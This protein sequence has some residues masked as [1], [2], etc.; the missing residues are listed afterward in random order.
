MSTIVDRFGSIVGKNISTR[1][2][3]AYSLLRIGYGA[4]GLQARYLSDRRLLPHQKYA[5]VASN[6][7]VRAPLI[8]PQNS[9]AVSMFLP[10]ELLQT[11]DI[12]PQFTEGLA[13]YLNGASCERA[14]IGYA[15]GAGVPQTYC[16][17]HKTLLGA[18]L[19]GVLPK[20]RFVVN[21][22]LACDANSGTFRALADHWHVPHFT[23]DV[24]YDGSEEAVVYVSDQFREMAAFMED[25]TERKLDEEKLKAVIYSENRSM[26]MYNDFFR[27]LSGKYMPND[28]T[29]EMSKI[30]FTHVL[31]GTREAERYFELLLDDVRRADS[32]NDEV[33]ILWVHSLPFWQRSIRNVFSFNTKYQLLCCDLNFDSLVEMDENRPY[34]SMA[35]K[36]LQNT[37]RGSGKRRAEKVLEMAKLLRADGIIYFCH[38]GCKQTTGGA[39]LAK[40][41]FEKAGIPTLVLDGDG[42]DR[43]NVNE[44]QTNTRLQA[45][46]EILEAAR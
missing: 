9:A 43:G 38:W 19:S 26:R 31:L 18:T 27:V 20:P 1:P 23:V 37:L 40:D 41:M 28:P 34:E 42:C 4:S 32:S 22:T 46:L 12:T 7:A 16:S 25:A 3:R 45:F 2:K 6:D 15:E 30:F 44:G 35:R 13:C 8:H 5:A 14:F 39:Y 24:P 21:T 10:C 36:V 33:R 29:S 17:Y 11:M